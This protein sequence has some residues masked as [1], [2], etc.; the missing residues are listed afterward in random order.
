MSGFGEWRREGGWV[1][2][3]REE[4]GIRVQVQAALTPCDCIGDRCLG[5]TGG[6][7]L[8]GWVC[9]VACVVYTSAYGGGVVP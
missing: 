5:M 6:V 4:D 9:P 8:G 2:E 7:S 3:V 1:E